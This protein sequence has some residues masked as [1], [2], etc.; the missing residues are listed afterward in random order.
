MLS[1][2]SKTSLVSNFRRGNPDGNATSKYGKVMSTDGNVMS[3]GGRVTSASADIVSLPYLM[4]LPTILFA[5]V[6]GMTIPVPNMYVLPYTVNVLM[7]RSYFPAYGDIRK[8]DESILSM[9]GRTVSLHREISG[10]TVFITSP[11]GLTTS[12]YDEIVSL[13]GIPFKSYDDITSAYGK[14]AKRYFF[15][16]MYMYMRMPARNIFALYNVSINMSRD[17]T[18]K[19]RNIFVHASDIWIPTGYNTLM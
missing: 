4:K 8:K 17:F 7:H 1:I 15:A 3:L 2:L 14:T 6:Y 16:I 12:P 13:P 18:A 19:Y 9:D 5:S 10:K 11:D